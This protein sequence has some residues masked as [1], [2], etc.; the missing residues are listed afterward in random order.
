MIAIVACGP[1][2]A[3]EV[4]RLTQLAYQGQELLDPPSGASRET[5]EKVR[6][7]LD[8][9]GGALALL[10]GEVVGCLRW[11]LHIDRDLYVKRLAVDPACR[12]RGVGSALMDWAESEARRRGLEGVILGVRIALADNLD[13]YRSLGYR[14][15]G[16]GRHAGYDRAT[17][18]WLRKPV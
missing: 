8:A 2:R 16:D 18:L 10:A 5:P 4:H 3:E 9:Y 7:Q 6:E 17:F 15:V 14:V 13:F 1:E 11:D 12:R